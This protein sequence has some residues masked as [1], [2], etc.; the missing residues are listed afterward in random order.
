MPTN[1]KPKSQ[2]RFTTLLILPDYMEDCKKI[3]KQGALGSYFCLKIISKL[4]PQKIF[5]KNIQI[6]GA[7]K[8]TEGIKFRLDFFFS[9]ALLHMNS[10]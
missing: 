4:A 3:K 8:P 6:L 9:N 2:S 10:R 5:P 7:W 1:P